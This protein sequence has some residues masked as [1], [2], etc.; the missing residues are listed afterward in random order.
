MESILPNNEY[1]E[2]EDRVYSNPQLA[3]DEGNKFIDNLRT[4]QGQQN[5]EIFTDTQRLGT[6]IPTNLGGLTGAESYFT[7][8]YQTPQTNYAV[9]NLRAA[10][11]ATALN[12]VL[13]NEQEKWKK[14]YNDAYR[15][16]QKR[17]NDK[18]NTPTTPDYSDLLKKLNY[19][20]NEEDNNNN[21]VDP[22]KEKPG[23]VL[24]MSE[25]ANKYQDPKTGNWFMLTAPTA[26]EGYQITNSGAGQFPVDGKT[27]TIDGKVFRYDAGTDMW[28]RQTYMFGQR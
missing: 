25:T 15:A 10:A 11:Q 16:Y 3:V 1:T 14:R 20:V 13:S 17:M 19:D 27:V 6:N 12:E 23:Q 2:F 22:F 8:R 7:S 26:M 18:T 28:Y 21:T 5:Q 9:A 24:P 4:A